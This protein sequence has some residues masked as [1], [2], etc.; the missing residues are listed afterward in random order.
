MINNLINFVINTAGPSGSSTLMTI[1]SAV[2]AL[3]VLMV[4][5][6]HV[7]SLKK[8]FRLGFNKATGLLF[9]FLALSLMVISSWI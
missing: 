1:S 4:F 9:I 7:K 6:D 2:I 8:G 5:A 3:G